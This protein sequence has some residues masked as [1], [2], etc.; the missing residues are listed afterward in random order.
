MTFSPCNHTI[1]AIPL[2]QTLGDKSRQTYRMNLGEKLALVNYVWYIEGTSENILIDAGGSPDYFR[3]SGIVVEDIQSLDSGLNKVGLRLRD[4]DLI[5]LTHLHVDHIG[6]ASRFVVCF[7]K[8]R[9][10]SARHS[11][12]S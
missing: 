1:H 11:F 2:F 7:R 5:I 4:I 10:T 9:T 6:Q 12:R 8:N 3:R